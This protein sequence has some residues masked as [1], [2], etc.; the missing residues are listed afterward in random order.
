M[1]WYNIK[2]IGQIWN[3]DYGLK[4]EKAQKF[5]GDCVDSLRPLLNLL[6]HNELNNYEKY[7]YLKKHFSKNLP[8]SP[9]KAESQEISFVANIKERTS[10]L[11]K[12]IESFLEYEK[13]SDLIDEYQKSKEHEG[14]DNFRSA[15]VEAGILKDGT[16]FDVKYI[17]AK[18]FIRCLEIS[19]KKLRYLR[20]YTLE[21]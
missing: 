5:Y 19:D 6:D 11:L 1:E 20:R 15:L 9:R 3:R 13:L 10:K 12:K 8:R 16:N 21:G 17:S 18:D 4:E 14:F 2:E 7:E